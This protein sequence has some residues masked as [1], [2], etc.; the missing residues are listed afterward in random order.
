[1]TDLTCPPTA[2][3]E[4]QLAAI[5]DLEG[6]VANLFRDFRVPWKAQERLCILGY[7]TMSDIAERWPTKEQLRNHGARDLGLLTGD[8][9]GVYQYG[10]FEEAATRALVRLS[11]A[12]EE[13]R[14]RVQQRSALLSSA[15]ATAAAHLITKA[16]RLSMETVYK[17]KTG[18]KPPLERQGSDQ[19]LGKCFKKVSDGY[20]PY[21]GLSEMVPFLLDDDTRL[22]SKTKRKRSDDGSV[23]EQD[24]EQ[25][26]EPVTR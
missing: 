6:D 3:T 9:D 26:E 22:V 7:T 8:G 4:D 19:F 13:A 11:G 14:R 18:R 23:T 20:V 21:F 5:I 25:I 17:Q 1:M 10:F 12:T 16:V 24:E 15:S 2:A